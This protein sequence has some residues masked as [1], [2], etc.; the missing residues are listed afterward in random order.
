MQIFAYPE[1]QE[2][3]KWHLEVLKSFESHKE[4]SLPNS[5]IEQPSGQPMLLFPEQ[6]LSRDM[7]FAAFIKRNKERLGMP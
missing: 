6:I 1:S 2:R 4:N 5:G 7:L 3:R